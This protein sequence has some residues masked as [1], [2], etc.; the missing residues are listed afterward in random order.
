MNGPVSQQR[1]YIRVT[2]AEDG[3]TPR[4]ELMVDGLK[5]HEFRNRHELLD[6]AMQ[7]VSSARY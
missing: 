5:V 2:M 3:R 4:Y 6:F 7:T 1:V